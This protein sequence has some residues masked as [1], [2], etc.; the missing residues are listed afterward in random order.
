M[1]ARLPA[2]AEA[3]KMNSII[4]THHWFPDRFQTCDVFIGKVTQPSLMVV[5][6]ELAF[7]T[8]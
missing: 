2:F 6:L 7:A 1:Q 8:L 3:L 4:E 5:C